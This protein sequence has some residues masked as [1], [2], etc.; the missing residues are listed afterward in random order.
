MGWILSKALERLFCKL[1]CFNTCGRNPSL[2]LLCLS[3]G[4]GK[5]K[6]WGFDSGLGIPKG[7]SLRD[8]SPFLHNI[9]DG[10]G[11][12]EV[13]WKLPRHIF[14]IYIFWKKNPENYHRSLQLLE[15]PGPK[16]FIHSFIIPRI[17]VN[18]FDVP[19]LGN[20]CESSNSEVLPQATPQHTIVLNNIILVISDSKH[21]LLTLS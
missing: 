6:E 19:G 12:Q 16:I 1:L 4:R 5:Y 2:S 17:L 11:L 13:T 8:W 9:V 10:E 18:G 3:W 20:T 15:R 14:S 7:N 21:W